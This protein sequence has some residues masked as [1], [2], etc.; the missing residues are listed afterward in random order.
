MKGLLLF[1]AGCL[2]GGAAIAWVLWE[3]PPPAP[4]T[5]VVPEAP[6]LPAGDAGPVTDLDDGTLA[7]PPPVAAGEPA[8]A[9]AA[10]ADAVGAVPPRSPPAAD[11]ARVPDLNAPV[12]DD[13]DSGDLDAPLPPEA[14]ALPV[15]AT[16]LLPP[17]QLPVDGI[18]IDDLDDTYTDAR[19]EGRRHDAID[20]MAAQGTPVRAV[21]DGTIAKLF[22]SVPGGKTIYQFDSDERVAFYYAHLD[23]YADGVVEGMNVRQ[24]D[25]IGYV[26]YTGN[27]NAAAPHLHFAVFVLGADKRWWEGTAI[28]PYPLLRGATEARR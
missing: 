9:D 11:A 19:G 1:L 15:P 8:D 2:V 16:P 6:A 25:L 21:A 12:G 13:I 20:I 28:N 24:G 14:V 5:A 17:L 22:L 23:R 3:T 7:S 18:G 26:G 4:P 10:I 27:A